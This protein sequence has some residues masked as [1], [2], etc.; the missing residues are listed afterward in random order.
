[1]KAAFDP[2]KLLNPDKAIPTLNRCAEYGRMR[3]TGGVLPHPELE[4]F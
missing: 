4:R 2:K 3:I 1:V